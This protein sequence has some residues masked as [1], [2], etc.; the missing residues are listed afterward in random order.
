MQQGYEKLIGK[1]VYEL[2]NTIVVLEESYPYR[3]PVIPQ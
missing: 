3:R 1:V 2:T